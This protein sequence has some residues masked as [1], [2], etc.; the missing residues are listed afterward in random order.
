MWKMAIKSSKM[1]ID[2]SEVFFALSKSQW[3]YMPENSFAGWM[4]WP[5][6]N[7]KIKKEKLKNAPKNVN[8]QNFWF[9]LL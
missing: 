6:E 7:T 1:K 2:K 9:F 3:A 5:V 8:F 4:G